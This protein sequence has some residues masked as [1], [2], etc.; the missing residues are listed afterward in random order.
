[1]V[2]EHGRN[3]VHSQTNYQSKEFPLK[4][5][6]FNSEIL[7]TYHL[8]LLLTS[9]FI[10]LSFSV[11]YLLVVERPLLSSPPFS[12]EPPLSNLTANN[13]HQCG[14]NTCSPDLLAPLASHLNST[15]PNWFFIGDIW[16]GGELTTLLN[17]T[18]SYTPNLY[19]D[20]F[21]LKKFYFL[22]MSFWSWNV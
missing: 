16:F 13:C 11:A 12:K 4:E 17:V 8:I 7:S 18:Y 19:V 6:C 1:M 2:S 10:H 22:I 14:E 21:H 15:L 5:L 3:L 20:F 9:S